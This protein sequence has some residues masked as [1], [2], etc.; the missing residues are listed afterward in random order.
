MA[1][2][3]LSKG[4]KKKLRLA[5]KAAQAQDSGDGSAKGEQQPKES[6]GIYKPTS[7]SKQPHAK[8]PGYKQ[9]TSLVQ[10]S[11]PLAHTVTYS[12]Q[13]TVTVLQSQVANGLG[14]K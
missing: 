9:G 8:K 4:Q 5:K 1:P 14:Q 3:P 12:P 13:D 11:S 7:Q 6:Q 10:F 2:Q